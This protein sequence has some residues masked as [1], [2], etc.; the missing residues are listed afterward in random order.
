MDHKTVVYL[1]AALVLP[2][3]VADTGDEPDEIADI[4]RT[5]VEFGLEL[6]DQVESQFAVDEAEKHAG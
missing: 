5:A 1:T 4:V 3:L 2:Q 6:V